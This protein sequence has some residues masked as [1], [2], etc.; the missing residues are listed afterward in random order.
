MFD[1]LQTL[2]APK[3]RSFLKILSVGF[4]HKKRIV[5]F[6]YF[7]RQYSC[8]PKYISEYIQ[9]YY[10]EFEIVW[11]FKNPKNFSFLKKKNI[12]T[13]KYMA[14][15]FLHLC[16]T[17]KFIISNSEI[18]SWFPIMKRQIY[19]NTWHGG[20]AYKKVGAAY[21]KET[22]GKQI[23]AEIA[24]E[25]PCIY[26]SSSK[27]FTELT[28]HQS[29][30]HYGDILSCGMPRNDILVNQNCPALNSKIRKYYQIPEDSKI[31][32]YAP[33]YRESKTADEYLFECEKI[34]KA[35][36][37]RFGGNWHFLFRMHYFI[38]DQ[39]KGKADYI[40]AS[41]YPDMQ[42]LLYASDVLITDYSSSMWDFGLTKKP[43]FLYATDLNTYDMERG[44]YS[45]IHTWPFALAETTDELVSIINNFD[46]TSY[47]K[48]LEKHF[49]DLGSYEKGQATKTICKY[50]Y[51][52]S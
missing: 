25:M 48:D 38:M 45:D 27:A 1:Y 39:L 37:E 18:P 40:D 15:Y 29:F 26:V 21:Q 49:S 50:I 8:N 10:P 42:E 11:G 44:F 22:K 4:F 46:S 31:M 2:I 9:K 36:S 14:P 13:A 17:S 3:L 12:R 34:K 5:F 35:L 41:N 43:C 51:T 28:I 23:R 6:S 24:R 20:G 7:G 16:L 32:L 19:I 52:H 33:T 30:H 47:Q